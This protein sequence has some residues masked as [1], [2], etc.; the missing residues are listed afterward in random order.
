MPVFLN[1]ESEFMSNLEFFL[2]KNQRLNFGTSITI[3]L[4]T[5]NLA[6]LIEN[7]IFENIN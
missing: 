4:E 2:N 1:D 6:F 7:P 3:L 5:I